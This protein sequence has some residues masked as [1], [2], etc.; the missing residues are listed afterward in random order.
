MLVL[1]V[2]PP[3][4]GGQ[5]GLDLNILRWILL[6]PVEFLR[7]ILIRAAGLSG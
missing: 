4:I 3:L 2:L 1:L 6:P 5:L 7:D